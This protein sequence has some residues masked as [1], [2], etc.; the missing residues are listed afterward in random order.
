MTRT[1]SKNVEVRKSAIHGRGV[2]ALR[3]YRPK[4]TVL[5]WSEPTP[6]SNRS[7][8]QMSKYLQRY[9]VRLGGRYVLLSAPERFVNHSCDPNTRSY[10]GRDIAKRTIR[11]GEEITS[12]YVAGGTVS[13]AFRC[14]C[15]SVNCRHTIQATE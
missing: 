6:I 8:K 13:Q 15:G 11:A 4:E 1:Q 9:V 7:S 2:F 3:Q 12:D 14:R 5:L 10:R